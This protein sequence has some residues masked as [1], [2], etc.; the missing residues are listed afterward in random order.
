MIN[1]N[2]RI[3]ARI[4]FSSYI[5]F[6]YRTVVDFSEG[7]NLSDPTLSV[8]LWA[9][10]GTLEYID[11]NTPSQSESHIGESTAGV[12]CTPS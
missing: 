12:L 4:A 10:P 11:S 8:F 7:V 2:M 3:Y 6:S 1:T 5:T 9:Q